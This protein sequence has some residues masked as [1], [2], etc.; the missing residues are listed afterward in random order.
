MISN[1]G[2]S[3][4]GNQPFLVTL[5]KGG[6]LMPTIRKLTFQVRLLLYSLKLGILTIQ[7]LVY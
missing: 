2:S 5:P 4:A 1:I 7:H 3:P 6:L